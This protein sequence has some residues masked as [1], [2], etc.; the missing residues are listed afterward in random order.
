M[1][2]SNYRVSTNSRKQS[3][4]S[5]LTRHAKAQRKAAAPKAAKTT[6]KKKTSSEGSF[7]KSMSS[8]HAIQVYGII[9][10]AFALL[11]AVSIFSFYFHAH[12]NITYVDGH[13]AIVSENIARSVGAYLA[14]FFVNEIFGVFSI[15]FP[16]LIFLYGRRTMA[17]FYNFCSFLF[18]PIPNYTSSSKISRMLESKM[19]ICSLVPIVIRL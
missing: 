19:S 1:K 4:T 8:P 10:M 17:S 14:Y 7:G 3:G 6:K 13:R 9:L 2:V 12:N 11:L 5:T 15:G 16:F 18:L